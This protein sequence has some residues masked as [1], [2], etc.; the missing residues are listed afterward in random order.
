MSY[1]ED[2][3]V[4]AQADYERLNMPG[5]DPRWGT[6][7][8]IGSA[9][10]LDGAAKIVTELLADVTFAPYDNAGSLAERKDAIEHEIYSL[11]IGTLSNL[12][13]HKPK[14]PLAVVEMLCRAADVGFPEVAYNAANGIVGNA[15]TTNDYKRAER[16]FKI[17][18]E[19]ETDPTKRAAAIVNYVPLIRDGLI[20]GKKDLIAAIEL[21]EKAARTGLVTAMY[22]AG[23]VCMWEVQAGNTDLIDR[24]A[25]W[26]AEFIKTNDSGAPLSAMDNPVFIAEAIQQAIKHLADFHINEKIKQPS[27][28][29][30]IAMA[31]R[32]DI[33]NDHDQVVKNWLL[34]V[35]LSK[36]LSSLSAPAARS[37][38][39]H[40]HYLLQNI[41]W[42][43]GPITKGAPNP[44]DTFEIKHSNGKVLMVVLDYL[45]DPSKRYSALDHLAI[46]LIRPGIDHVFVV[47]AIGMF[48]ETE[49]GIHV[50]VFVY[51][52]DSRAVV[53]LNQRMTPE[54]IIE[55][56]QSGLF[57]MDPRAAIRNC[58][59]P[60]TLN[61]LNSGKKISDG[62]NYNA[63]YAVMNNVC[64]PDLAENFEVNSL[65]PD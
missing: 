11:V 32:I 48:N 9:G 14:L 36:R 65:Q 19:T 58:V 55:N 26:F 16:Y 7:L 23:N 5:T 27:L 46:S 1:R 18:I 17:A 22:N 57:F 64:V 63:R 28:E 40:W 6:A 30:G 49:A 53:S 50:P 38:A 62:V 52:N 8:K 13:S 47:S 24:A 25:Y 61:M 51:T 29:V 59:L 60:I 54:E 21:Y 20:T 10:N 37:G 39:D 12:C 35:G 44:F 33:H 42:D 43:V 31:R 4:L 15:S 2:M 56:T 34:E 41:D 45:F 3:L